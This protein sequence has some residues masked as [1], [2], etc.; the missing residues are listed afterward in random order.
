MIGMI[1]KTAF[2]IAAAAVLVFVVFNAYIATKNL[3][4]VRENVNL[5]E[6]ATQLR[7]EI[8]AL[9]LNLSNLESGQ[10][11]YLLTEDPAYLQPYTTAVEQLPAQFASLRSK[12]SDRP[13]DVLAMEAELES[14][15]QA[16]VAEAEETIR[17]RR[18]G[19]RTR[20][21][22]IVNSNSGKEVMD[23][24]R[25][26][27]NSLLTA[28]GARLSDLEQTASASMS[29]AFKTTIKWNLILLA[30]TAFVFGLHWAYSR[31][32][33]SDVAR[34]NHALRTTGEQLETLTQTV[35]QKLPDVLKEMQ[36]SLDS[37]LHQFGDYLPARG[38]EHAAQ[39]RDMAAQS[40][41]LM[42]SSLQREAARTA[43]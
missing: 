6:Q 28:E 17:L 11:G 16:A 29:Q 23:K 25:E 26:L 12:L 13:A 38:Q 39:I 30:L 40:N 21:F 9:L 37:F 2:L 7:A 10:R 35:S 18:E 42:T 22:R 43:A 41:R 19:Y 3:H 15:A 5:R 14:L 33:E 20:A 24:S 32:L 31:R 34:R 36:V 27:A 8:S 4:S 1:R